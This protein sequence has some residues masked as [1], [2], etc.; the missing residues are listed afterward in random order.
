MTRAQCSFEVGDPVHSRN[1]FFNC[2]QRVVSGFSSYLF[3]HS[4]LT[5]FLGFSPSEPSMALYHFQDPS[6]DLVS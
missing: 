2:C 3:G 1:P 6:P 5:P 4:F